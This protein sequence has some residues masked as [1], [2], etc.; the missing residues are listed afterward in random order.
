MAHIIFPIETVNRELL[1]KSQLAGRLAANGF[2]CYL[3]QKAQLPFLLSRLSPCVYICKGYHKDLTEKLAGTIKNAGGS[4]VGLDEEGAVDF[5]GFPTIEGRYPEFVFENYDRVFLWGRKQSEHLQ[6][7]R[8]AFDP[9]KVEVSGHPRFENLGENARANFGELAAAIRKKEGPF[10]LLNSNSG[11][12]N[13]L[14]GD[15]FVRGN[16]ASRVKYLEQIIRYD[17]VKLQA[18][19]QLAAEIL[20]NTDYRIIFRTHPEESKETYQKL[21]R[22]RNIDPGRCR[23][24]TE[25]SVLPW[26]MACD[27]IVHPDSTSAVEAYLV[28]KQPLS[29]LPEDKDRLNTVLPVEASIAFSEVSKLVTHI[30]TGDKEL[31][32]RFLDIIN[33]YIHTSSS[34]SEL[35]VRE[36]T[37]LYR[38]FPQLQNGLKKRDQWFL[39]G[40]FALQALKYS[41]YR[42]KQTRFAMQKSP[43]LLA[44]KVREYINELNVTGLSI[45]SIGKKIIHIGPEST[46]RHPAEQGT[47]GEQLPHAQP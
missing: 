4:I 3:T 6:Q 20:E 19:V 27:Y 7:R 12:G 38:R 33:E 18:F 2:N 1:Y 13:N 41:V 5:P 45:N 11:F 25:H 35:I 32:P 14:K 40:K 10:I 30:Q 47:L 26:I 43:K 8:T 42:T 9:A 44:S 46:A 37:N 28:G 31:Q 15:D 22:S 16:Y 39:R 36:L 23:I 29:L 24:D 34:S 17:K 21:L